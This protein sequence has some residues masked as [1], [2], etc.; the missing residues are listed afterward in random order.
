MSV[1]ILDKRSTPFRQLPFIGVPLSLMAFLLGMLI[2]RQPS[3]VLLGLV[4]L[5]ILVLMLSRIEVGIY[6]ILLFVPVE[7][8]LDLFAPSSLKYLDEAILLVIFFGLLLRIFITRRKDFK[9][10]PLDKPL[11]VFL[12]IAFVSIVINKVPLS[13]GLAGLRAFLQYVLLY[14]VIIYSEI[15]LSTLK[16]M[17]WLSVVVAAVLSVGGVIQEILGPYAFG[18]WF[19]GIAENRA[20][21]VG[22]MLRV[23]STMANP[24]TFGTYLSILLPVTLGL[25][26]YECRLKRRVILFLFSAPM[27]LAL[28]LTFSRESWVGLLVGIAVVGVLIDKRVLIILFVLFLVASVAFPQQIAGRLLEGFSLKYLMSSYGPPTAIFHGGGRVFY[29]VN[30]MKVVKDNF[31]FGVGPGRYGGSVAAIFKTPVYKKYAIPMSMA[32]ID[33]FWMQLWGE[34]GTLGLIVFLFM[35]GRFFHEARRIV[36]NDETP[37]FLKG[38]TAGFM[39][40]FVAVLIEALAANIFEVHT[41]MLFFWF[42]MAVVVRFGNELRCN[43]YSAKAI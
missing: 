12:L 30:T 29:Y 21:R 16:K 13:V 38:L 23:F 7:L 19:M 43:K 22:S 1:S 4:S 39:V 34:V 24:N 41:T 9:S 33:T 20:F 10:T 28:I 27:I 6:F 3:L 17:V 42:F 2:F 37:R 25:A 32:Q 26:L 40:G 31:L 15:S 14:Y 35:L 5:G 8:T 18:G 36:L 11:I